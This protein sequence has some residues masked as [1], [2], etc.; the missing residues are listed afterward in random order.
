MST[1][2]SLKILATA[3][4]TRRRARPAASAWLLALLAAAG[5]ALLSAA[6]AQ[7]ASAPSPARQDPQATATAEVCD[8]LAFQSDFPFQDPKTDPPC[9]VANCTALSY[10]VTVGGEHYTTTSPNTPGVRLR[11]FRDSLLESERPG[12]ANFADNWGCST[13]G[14]MQC[15]YDP[16]GV[17]LGTPDGVLTEHD[18]WPNNPRN[19]NWANFGHLLPGFNL[20]TDFVFSAQIR[21]DINGP[22]DRGGGYSAG[23]ISGKDKTNHFPFAVFFDSAVGGVGPYNPDPTAPDR[24]SAASSQFVYDPPAP[25]MPRLLFKA[26]IAPAAFPSFRRTTPSVSR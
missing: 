23:L 6:M 26:V 14:G 3:C 20:M 7:G 13:D 2:Y 5:F 25:L 9:T 21:R 1:P 15:G 11:D 16:D 4:A 17:W 18:G 12:G 24:G 8:K 10:N 19:P 22:E